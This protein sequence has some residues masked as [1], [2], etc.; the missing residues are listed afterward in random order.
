[1]PHAQVA[2][3]LSLLEHCGGG[4]ARLVKGGFLCTP[5]CASGHTTSITFDFEATAGYVGVER[6]EVVMFNCPEWGISVDSITLYGSTIVTSIGNTLAVIIPTI[7]S[8]D[9]LVRVCI[10]SRSVNSTIT[11]QLH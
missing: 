8:C 1:M 3:A 5:G 4:Y 6:V 2:L 9:S 10:L 11:Q 7:T